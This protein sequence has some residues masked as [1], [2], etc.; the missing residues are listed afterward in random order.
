M[1]IGELSKKTGVSV[2]A[3]RHYED[4]ALIKSPQRDGKYR[5][6]DDSYIQVL[7]MIKAAKGLGFTLEELRT[8]AKAKTQEGLVPMDLLKAELQKKRTDILVKKAELEKRLEEMD[9]LEISVQHY[10]QC[11]LENINQ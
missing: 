3:I 11:L 4:I 1:Y 2:K 5:V 7:G 9:E 8:I 10:N 6:Y